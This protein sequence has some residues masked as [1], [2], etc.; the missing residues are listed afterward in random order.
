[1]ILRRTALKPRLAIILG[2]GFGPVAQ[3]VEV[4]REFSY[5]DLTGFTV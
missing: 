1:L 4:E 2:S 5:R 3:A